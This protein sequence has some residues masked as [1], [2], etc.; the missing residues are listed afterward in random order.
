MVWNLFKP[1]VEM[2]RS[3]KSLASL[4][5]T[6]PSETERTL[7][8]KNGHPL[9]GLFANLR[10]LTLLLQMSCLLEYMVDLV[11]CIYSFSLYCLAKG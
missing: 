5:S 8:H 7:F 10:Y 6:A 11:G 4:S 9:R 1:F 2:S 3:L